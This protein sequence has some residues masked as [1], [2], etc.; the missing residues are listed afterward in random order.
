MLGSRYVNGA[1]IDASLVDREMPICAAFIAIVSFWPSPTIPV[2]S[3]NPCSEVTIRPFWS[4]VMRAK[5][6]VDSRTRWKASVEVEA[7]VRWRN[8]SPVTANS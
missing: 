5:T 8:T 7:D 2:Y 4:G 3:F 1:A 6:T